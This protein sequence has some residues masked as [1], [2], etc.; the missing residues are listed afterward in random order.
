MSNFLG[1][2]FKNFS[3]LE[4]LI[5]G[6]LFSV[7]KKNQALTMKLEL[8]QLVEIRLSEVNPKQK[9]VAKNTKPITFNLT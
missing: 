2:K 7:S 9:K 6:L 8:K 3:S 4:Y 5:D 1:N